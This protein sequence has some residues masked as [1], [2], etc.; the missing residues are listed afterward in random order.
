[1]RA[2]Q[3]IPHDKPLSQDFTLREFCESATADEH[4]IDIRVVADSPVH[5]HLITLTERILQPLRSAL[6]RPVHVSSGYRPVHVNA[7]VGGAPDSQHTRGKA[8]DID[9]GGLSPLEVAR[10]IERLGLPFDQLI[11]EFGHW[12]HVSYSTRQRR[13]CL[14]AYT[15]ADGATQYAP[16][17]QPIEELTP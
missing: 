3:Y 9:V 16:G 17:L 15:D 8:A 7:L 1:M 4:G 12:V 11:H 14:T 13:E 6:A 10:E 2:M 5:R